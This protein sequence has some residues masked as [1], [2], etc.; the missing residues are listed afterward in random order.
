[1][2]LVELHELFIK[3]KL[4]GARNSKATIYNYRKIFDLLLQFDHSITLKDLQEETLIKFLEYLNTR[5]R[6]VGKEQII[7]TYKNSSIAM[8]R[9]RLN[10]FF[11]WLLERNCLNV[12]PF[13]KIPYP[14][15]SY[16]DRRAFSA[17]EFEKICFVVN[18]KIQWSNLLV[19]KRNSAIIMVLTFTGLRKEELLGLQ[20]FDI[21]TTGKFISVRGETSKSK[22]S[23]II[24]INS[25]LIPYLEDYLI[26][27]KNY[28]AKSFWVSGVLDRDLTE[29]GL[30][31]LI[32]LLTK[33]SNVNCHLH[34][35]RH[36]FAT[37]YY[38]QTH[39]IVGLKKLMGH[40]SLKMTLSYLRSLP[41]E[42]TVEQIEKISIDE[43]I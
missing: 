3:F 6:K 23:R 13:E 35:F 5:Q 29:H 18:T 36:T 10:V 11:N 32:N 39:D 1:M 12:N 28:S 38:K 24:P 21:D 14:E 33:H 7:R 34:R 43:F 26:F 9:S 2:S 31:H 42:H 8:V 25:A 37:N 20:L 41:D 30:K 16:T 19:K 27:R 22:R 40:R 15:V 17:K 4:H